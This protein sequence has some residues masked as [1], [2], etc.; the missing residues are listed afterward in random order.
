MDEDKL[1]NVNE[2]VDALRQDRIK[3]EI[4]SLRNDLSDVKDTWDNEPHNAQSRTKYVFQKHKGKLAILSA[5]T[6][7]AF[8]WLGAKLPDPP[9]WMFI[10]FVGSIIGIAI[11]FIPARMVA[12]MFVTDTRKPILELDAENFDTEEENDI[13]LYYVPQERIPDIE[14]YEGEMFDMRTKK[15]NGYQVEK[16]AEVEKNGRRH[17]IAKGT[18][19]GEKSSLELARNVG[20]ITGMRETL[21]PKAQKGF[22]YEV[23]WPH[24]MQELSS[25]IANMITREIEGVAIFKG[26]SLRSKIDELTEKYNPDNIEDKISEGDIDKIEHSEEEGENAIMEMLADN[27]KTENN[28]D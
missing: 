17:L 25:S 15:G 8:F 2:K 12:D 24:I 16:F 10:M 11:G 19:M 5:I 23:M 21:K 7:L 3:D 27:Q 20:N 18:W 1:Q 14:V 13:A 6:L 28:G 9:T 22:A 4:L 26:P